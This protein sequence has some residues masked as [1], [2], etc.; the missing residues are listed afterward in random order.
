MSCILPRKAI[1]MRNNLSTARLPVL[2]VT[3]FSCPLDIEQ[4]R[5]SWSGLSVSSTPCYL[6][7]SLSNLSW[8]WSCEF[9]VVEV[10]GGGSFHLTIGKT[11]IPLQTAEP[12]L[13]PQITYRNT[14]RFGLV[15]SAMLFFV[16]LIWDVWLFT[17]VTP[18][19]YWFGLLAGFIIFYMVCHCVGVIG[20]RRSVHDCNIV[21]RLNRR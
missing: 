4:L 5:Q 2:F 19:F 7:V 16:T 9:V 17:T 15:S 14:S 18:A 3:D 13:P 12:Q 1:K 20:T 11:T 10:S 21:S 6:T 8:V